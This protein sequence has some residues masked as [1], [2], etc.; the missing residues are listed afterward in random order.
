MLVL[1]GGCQSLQVAELRRSDMY[2]QNQSEQGRTNAS[3][4]AAPVSLSE[5]WMYDANA[6][7]GVAAPLVFGEFLVVLNRKGEVHAVDV[8]SGRKLGLERFGEAING[9]AVLEDGVLF[10]PLDFGSRRTVMAWDLRAG[11]A[12]WRVD[13]DHAV[14]SALVLTDEAV[15]AIDRASVITAYDKETGA[16]KWSASPLPDAPII[17]SPS[18]TGRGDLIV[19]TTKGTIAAISGHDG[20]LLWRTEMGEPVYE[21]PAVGETSA[22]V[23]GTHGGI[24]KIDVATGIVVWKRSLTTDVV[25]LTSPAVAD[26]LVVVAGTDGMARALR[27]SS[28]EEIWAVSTGYPVAAPPLLTANLVFVGTLGST[29]LA[30]DRVSGER[31][32]QTELR[33][34]VK[35]AMTLRNGDLYLSS[36]PRYIY[37]FGAADANEV[38]VAK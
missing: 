26:E 17:A 16:V 2:P 14:A 31:G 22:F 5:V 23:S 24:A 37:R 27:Q 28:G 18:L 4:A 7:F 29:V 9:D 32:W 11:A 33:G 35:S 12:K 19:A 8:D 10:V 34:R 21:S 3:D 1:V 20:S 30:L 38:A 25:K 15:V 13:G 6:G 36:E